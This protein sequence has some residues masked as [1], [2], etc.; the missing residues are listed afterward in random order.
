MAFLSRRLSRAV[1]GVLARRRARL[2]AMPYAVIAIGRV[3]AAALVARHRD[4][5]LACGTPMTGLAC[6][7]AEHRRGPRGLERLSALLACPRVRARVG[8]PRPATRRL[9]R[10]HRPAVGGL[11]YPGGP[12][13]VARLVIPVEVGP[14]IKR[15]LG[16]PACSQAS[17]ARAEVRLNPRDEVP[18]V[19]PFGADG[20]SPAAVIL[21]TAGGRLLAPADHPLPR[22]NQRVRAGT[23]AATHAVTGHGCDLTFSPQASARQRPLILGPLADEG[24][25]RADV[26]VAAVADEAGTPKDRLAATLTSAGNGHFGVDDD[27]AADALPG[28]NEQG[29]SWHTPSVPAIYVNVIEHAGRSR[30]VEE[31]V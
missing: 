14:A 19:V 23:L 28:V 4:V 6:F 30:P 2:A 31:V 8:T 26:L 25:K 21:V 27:A 10:R 7:G 3:S 1:P 29:C 5:V 13:D 12:A 17:R 15:V 18:H 16:S 9:A 24:L 22:F 11:L 20:D